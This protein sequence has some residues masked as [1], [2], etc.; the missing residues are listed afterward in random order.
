MEL[1]KYDKHPSISVVFMA[2]SLSQK[3]PLRY[4]KHYNSF[5]FYQ[6]LNQYPLR[7]IDQMITSYDYEYRPFSFKGNI[8][9]GWLMF[10]SDY[11]SIS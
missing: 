6:I 9:L 10:P 2:T 11:E 8:D 7:G 3:R 5:H 4:M 1:W